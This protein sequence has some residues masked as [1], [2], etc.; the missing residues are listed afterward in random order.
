MSKGDADLTEI[1]PLILT[2]DHRVHALDAKVTLDDNAEFRHEEWAPFK[3]TE[4]LDERETFAREKGLNYIGLDGTVG[5]IGNGAGLV[6][7]TLDVVNQAGGNAANFL[8]VGGGAGAELL[9]NAIE[10]VNSDDKVR[11]HTHQH[12]RRNHP[13]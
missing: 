9:A 1:N 12:L 13:L 3:A 7:S 2:P 6:M 4:V 5:I 10:V 11:V 8:D